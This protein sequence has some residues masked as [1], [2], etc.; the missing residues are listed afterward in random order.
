MLSLSKGTMTMKEKRS[1]KMWK[2]ENNPVKKDLF[3]GKYSNRIKPAKRKE[4]P[5]LK[6][7][8]KEYNDNSTQ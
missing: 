8:L 2:W 7:G 4:G 6:E 1:K 5:S 3:S